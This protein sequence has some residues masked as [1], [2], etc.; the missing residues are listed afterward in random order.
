MLNQHQ[1]DPF[2]KRHLGPRTKEVE[3]MLK[4]VG[5]S[6]IDKLINDVVPKQIQDTQPLKLDQAWTEFDILDELKEIASKNDIYQSFIGM[7][8]YNCIT[9]PI[10]QRNI[11]ENPSWYTAYTPYQAEVAQGQR[12]ESVWRGYA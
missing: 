1:R 7:G 8:Y 6:S 12:A 11:L 9:P 2:V 4:T 5:Y 10:I 3:L